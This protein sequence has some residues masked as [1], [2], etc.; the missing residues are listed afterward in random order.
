MFSKPDVPL[1]VDV[2]PLLLRLKR[3]LTAVRDDTLP[4]ENW[5]VDEHGDPIPPEPTDPVFRVAA[6][7]SLLMMDKYWAL[8][9]ECEIYSIAM[10]TCSAVNLD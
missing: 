2:Y 1:I 7:A 5:E 3:A 9:D 4:E 6:Q 10:G 8:L